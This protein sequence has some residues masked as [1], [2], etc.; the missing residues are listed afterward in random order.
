[1]F[2]FDQALNLYLSNMQSDKASPHTLKTYSDTLRAYAAHCA[3]EALDVTIPAAVA[4]W[5]AGMS[6]KGNKLATIDMRLN[7]LRSFF[8]FAATM[9]LLQ[10]ENTETENIRQQADPE[11]ALPEEGRKDREGGAALPQQHGER[12][13]PI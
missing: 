2:N 7:I 13:I 11:G 3:S 10:G 9:K 6:A 8:D 4:S 12:G 1:M 5:K